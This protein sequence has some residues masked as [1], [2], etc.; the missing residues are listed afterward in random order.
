MAKILVVDDDGDLRELIRRMIV[1]KGHSVETAADGEQGV[2][3]AQASTPDLILMDLN[4][5]VMDGFEATRRIRGID[6]LKSIPL[7]ALTA[8]TTS[9][10]RDAIYQA[11]CTAFVNKPLD[12]DQLF[13]RINEELE[14]PGA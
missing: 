5:P 14:S 12:F 4:M 1:A 8:E 6:A 13:R 9:E 3:A 11:G 7:V 10:Q 2:R